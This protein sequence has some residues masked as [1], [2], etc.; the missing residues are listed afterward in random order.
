MANLVKRKVRD[1]KTPVDYRY[2]RFVNNSVTRTREEEYR[3]LLANEVSIIDKVTR[4]PIAFEDEIFAKNDLIEGQVGYDK[5]TKKFY[6]VY[7]MG[8]NKYGNPTRLNF[9]TD[10]GITFIR[11]AYY[12]NDADGAYLIKAMPFGY[13][14]GD[15]IRK[16]TDFITECDTASAQN[17]DACKTPYIVVCKDANLRKSLDTAIEQ[18]TLGQ[19]VVVVNEELGDG[20]KAVNIGVQ[21]L[22]D[23]FVEIRDHEENKLLNKLGILTANTAKKE[24]VQ[25]AEVNS[26]L[27]VSSDYIYL[28]I[29][30]FNKQCETY[31]LPFEMVFNGSMEELYTNND[32]DD[33]IDVN[34]VEQKS[35]A[36][37][38]ERNKQDD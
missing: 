22:V 36:D 33:I 32:E 29:D 17:L 28:F 38:A 10:N 23:K 4:K 2:G 1:L 12:D 9:V 37:V 20:L 8:R 6:H 14:F 34:D 13:S 15:L 26:T 27:N 19:A 25:S 24:R 3:N 30:T 7:G 5:I 21:Y 16:A 11:K 18:K 31:D 35:D